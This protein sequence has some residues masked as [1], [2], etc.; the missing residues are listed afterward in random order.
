MDE[1]CRSLPDF[2]V[3]PVEE[4]EHRLVRLKDYEQQSCS[5]IEKLKEEHE[6]QILELQLCLTPESPPEVREQCQADIQ[7]S[8]AKISDIV[9]SAAKLL[10]DSVE[11]WT[12]LQE[13]PEVR[14]LQETI[15]HR[16]TELDAVKVA[17][18]TLPP[19]EKMLKVKRSNEL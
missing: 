16:Q 18:K 5:E 14:Q 6:A 3:Q 11:A 2:D 7:A 8:T 4:L 17:I 13:H 1:A 19:M 9:S 15:R 12:T 10:E